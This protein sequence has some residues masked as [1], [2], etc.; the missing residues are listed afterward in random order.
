ME[1]K[2]A[3]FIKKISICVVRKRNEGLSF[4]GEI[5]L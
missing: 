5:N 4:L 1:G 2:L 3:D